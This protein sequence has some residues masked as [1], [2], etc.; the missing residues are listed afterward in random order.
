VRET[1]HDFYFV[2]VFQKSPNENEEKKMKKSLV[3][4][5]LV[6]LLCGTASLSAQ[7]SKSKLGIGLILFDRSILNLVG[8]LSGASLDNLGGAD[9][10]SM[11]LPPSR[12]H[13]PI[14]M[15]N[16][17][18]E[19]EFGLFRQSASS[20]DD[21]GKSTQSSMAFRVGSGVFVVSHLNKMDFYY[22]GRIGIVRVSQSDKYEPAKGKSTES[23][24][25]QTNLYL[26]PCAGGEY[27]IN[28]QFSFGGEAQFLYT[29]YGK[30]KM[31]DSQSTS[32]SEPETS[33]S[34]MDTRY[35]FIF[36][37]YIN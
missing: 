9:E 31:E 33:K 21:F 5:V 14:N 16:L 17:K 34:L 2:S 18:L 10:L 28:E 15:G 12:L 37:W 26:G 27:Y 24:G 36:R 20:E 7:E 29:K 11:M 35:L 8:S 30:F 25:S 19:P 13:I 3:V 1:T 23:K 32:A 6:A 4:L 22:G